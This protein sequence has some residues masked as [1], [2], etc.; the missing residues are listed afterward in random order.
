MKVYNV[1]I[2][3]LGVEPVAL[4]YVGENEHRKI[5]FETHGTFDE[6]PG[7]SPALVV[8]PPQGDAYPV[9]VQREGDY[10]AWVVSDSDLIYDGYGELQLQFLKNNVIAKSKV[11]RTRIDKSIEPT[12]EV[13][14]PIENWLDEA[15]EALA[16]FPKG[17]TTGQVLTKKS[18]DDFDTEWKTPQGG[19]G[20]GGTSDY[21]DLENK[22]SIGGVELIGNKSLHDLGAAAE[23]DIP[24]V[25]GKADKV[26]S[27]TS[28]DFAALDANG[29]LTDSG[30]KATDFATPAD[31]NAKYTKPGSGIPTSDLASGVQTSLG[32]ADSAY[33]K[34]GGGIPASDLASGVLTSIID[35]TAGTGDT[36][37]TWSADFTAK[38]YTYVTPEDFGA[39]G[40]GLTDDTT[41]LQNCIDYARTNS[42]CIKGLNEYKTTSMLTITGNYQNIDIASINYTGEGYALSI[43]GSYSSIR[44][45]LL[46]CANGKGLLMKRTS[47]TN[48]R[49]IRITMNRLYAKGHAV[50]FETNDLFILYNT[51]DI[52]YIKSDTGDCYHCN[53]YVGENVFMNSSCSCENGW[54]IYKANGKYYNFTLEA[55]VLNG[56]YIN[57][58][59]S[60]FSGF[61]F[62]EMV[63]KLVAR[64]N[65]TYPDDRGGILIK[66]VGNNGIS[67]YTSRFISEDY[68]PYEA[69]D[70]SEMSTIEDILDTGTYIIDQLDKLAFCQFI[71][72]PIRIGNWDTENGY[73]TPGRMMVVVAGKKICIPA[74][75]TVYTITDADY[76][77]RD[78]Q[79][80]L[81][82]AKVFPTKM[83]IG[84]DGCVIHLPASYC[85]YGYSEFVVDQNQGHLC[86]I[87]D[88]RD[89]VNPIFNGNTLG[90][91]VYRLKAYCDISTNAIT[92]NTQFHE[93]N[94]NDS[95]NYV[96]EITRIDNAGGN[97]G[98]I[99]VTPEEFGAKGDG[100][101]DD[102]QAV[103]DAV[104]A[105]Y[106]V[107]FAN[108]K[109]YFLASAVTINHDCHLVGGKETVIKTKT[110]QSGTINSAFECS[111]TLKNTTTITTDYK[112]VGNTNNVGDRFE[113]ADMDGI[114]VGDI[115][116]I[117]ATDQYYS[118]ARAYYYLGGALLV[119]DVTDDYIYTC[120]SLPFD[121]NKTGNVSVK[122]YSAP[123]VIMDDLHFVS[124]L[125]SVGT[126]V[127][128]VQFDRCKNSVMRNCSVSKADNGIRINE[129]VNML[130]D[131]I[132][133]SQMP[134]WVNNTPR[135]HY[136]VGLYSSTNTTI[137]RLMGNT[138]NSCIDVSGTFP[139][140]NTRITKSNLFATNRH[141][142][143][144]MHESAYNT[145]LEDCVIGGMTGYGLM[146]IN[147]CRFVQSYKTG[148]EVGISYRGGHN[149]EWSKLYVSDCVFESVNCGVVFPSIIPQSP[150][151]SFDEVIGEVK[152]SNCYGG[153]LEFQPTLSETVLSNRIISLLLDNW[154]NCYEFWHKGEGIIDNMIVN[155]CSF[156]YKLWMNDHNGGLGLENIR[157]LTLKSDA[158]SQSKMY[159]DIKK[160]GGK[161]YLPEG[162]TINCSSGTQTDLYTVCGKNVMPNK[163]ADL[164]VGSVSG[165]VGSQLTTSVHS[166]FTSAL[167]VNAD[168]EIVFTQPN[169]TTNASI[170]PKCLVYVP[171]GHNVKMSCKLKNTGETTGATFRSYIAVVS[172]KTGLITYRNNGT[173]VQASA[174]GAVT[175]HERYIDSTYGDSMVLFYLY[176]S[177]PVADSET[178]LS[179]YVAEVLDG[180]FDT[181]VF[182]KYNGTT[183]T[184]D[185]TLTS[186]AGENNLLTNASSNFDMNFKV[187][188]LEKGFIPSATGVSF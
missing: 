127:Y 103:Q 23:S 66:Y 90:A 145:I 147:R 49:G 12:G 54:A 150:I 62:R 64:I 108:N 109:T 124:D 15:E 43:S 100:T 67:G 78:A 24:D 159:A 41:A 148:G 137:T 138:A 102:S 149:K 5:L 184:G 63:D 65:G 20:G 31:V 37:K 154:K 87:Y 169:N 129:C 10:V 176:C 1:D 110:P 34:P 170:F 79:I 112:Q 35:D 107:R 86:T 6:Y 52:R 11:A 115:M 177:T 120:D 99:Y 44:I 47:S 163:T 4:G 114:N 22:P 135:D 92:E 95:E 122:I 111:G 132:T 96:W 14:E 181:L 128:P 172:C 133:I 40:D 56:I 155:N 75:E 104:D 153:R 165:S 25:T 125:D 81:N 143:F 152:I 144:G 173:T 16:C 141:N 21:E 26:Q 57:G 30:K 175:T 105:G 55:D 185:G 68:V 119:A 74:H 136:G 156:G 93:F 142:G 42:K 188:L 48:C 53:E 178:T 157:Q 134:K 171:E 106:E 167:S 84:V 123:T 183:R 58:G 146:Y 51:F 131:G 72:A 180:D 130:L 126:Y 32:K 50:D 187:D 83:I 164:S 158:P 2:W 182:E 9:V 89:S 61:R 91:G 118:Y 76:D 166:A 113:F 28:G 139:S 70:T 121:I 13:P 69:I 36:G 59:S 85:A 88:S 168:G 94:Y 117:T 60:Y 151:Q 3:E 39:V 82:E 77:M 80:A 17:G 7:C 174:E 46:Y 160:F 8:R 101:T 140:I 19:G 73:T 18:N 179:E 45:N 71:D 27:A 162:I 97:A 33:Q 38:K 186:V 29:N 161:Y 98:K 116:V